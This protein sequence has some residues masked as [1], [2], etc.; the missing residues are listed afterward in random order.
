MRALERSFACPEMIVLA[1]VQ[2][3]RSLPRLSNELKELSTIAN[4][5]RNSLYTMKMLNQSEYVHSPAIFYNILGKLN[6]STRQRW[7]DYASDFDFLRFPCSKL[8][9][10][11]NFLTREHERHVKFRLSTELSH[12]AQ[13][14]QIAPPVQH[15]SYKPVKRELVHSMNV[16]KNKTS[17][18]LE[19]LFCKRDHGIGSCNDYKSLS[20][21]DRWRWLRQNKICYKCLRQSPH[22]W[23]ACKVKP[24]GINGC[25]IRHYPLLHGRQDT[26]TSTLAPDTHFFNNTV[27]AAASDN[28]NLHTSPAAA[29]QVEEKVVVS[30]TGL[31][32][33]STV[34]DAVFQSHTLLKVVP[35]TVFG[36]AGSYDTY[37]LLDDG[38]SATIIELSVATHIGLSGPEK[39][40]VVEGVGGLQK[41]TKVSLVDFH[42]RGQHTIDIHPVR[43]AR[44]MQSLNLHTQTITRE[45]L[46]SYSHL[47]ELTDVLT[48]TNAKPTVLIGA[49]HWYLSIT[50]AI[51][52]GKN[53]EPVHLLHFFRL[54]VVRRGLKQNQ[55]YRICQSL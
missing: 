4:K 5:V 45:K 7:T 53:N 25:M 22:Q 2:E 10:L 42:I 55:A 27:C 41:H 23:K 20:V 50:Q 30:N 6:S 38:S 11:S 19:C 32:Q 39:Q 17:A 48:H 34:S 54:D 18:K 24:C 43:R 29:A 3:L 26:S 46:A 52:K 12:A 37:A 49:Q 44:A 15:N 1:E 51:R 21:D 13:C 28:N 40:I 36:P 9:A 14:L 16:T 8:E 33:G 47:A 35:I 31:Q